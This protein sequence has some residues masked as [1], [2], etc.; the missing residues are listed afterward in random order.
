MNYRTYTNA[1]LV[2][3]L[4]ARQ[5]PT[6]PL[7]EA[8]EVGQPLLEEVARRFIAL[9]VVEREGIDELEK[10]VEAAERETELR[11]EQIGFAQQLLDDIESHLEDAFSAP[12]ED[13]TRD[14]LIQRIAHEIKTSAFER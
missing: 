2:R 5:L 6:E 10:Q 12:Q 8:F 4:E 9:E 14:E 3:E 1:E 13:I 7:T 11:E